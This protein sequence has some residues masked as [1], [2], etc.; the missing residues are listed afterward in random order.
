[1]PIDP[2]VLSYFGQW[3]W[4]TGEVA[5]KWIPGAAISIA[6]PQDPSLPNVTIPIFTQ[7]VSVPAVSDYFQFTATPEVSAVIFYYWTLWIAI[8]FFFSLFFGYLLVHSGIR[9]YRV[10]REER[11][12]FESQH[13]TVVEKNVPKTKLRWLHLQDQLSSDNEHSWRV[14]VLE[15]DVMLGELLDVQ[16]YRGETMA[17]K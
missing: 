5:F 1:M 17:D 6:L 8:S 7:A 13:A 10:R 16:G 3:A 12:F 2:G 4:F 14:A 9:I 11:R 15:A